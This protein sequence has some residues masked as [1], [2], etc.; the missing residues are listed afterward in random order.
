MSIIISRRRAQTTNAW[1][2]TTRV[3][4][5]TMAAAGTMAGETSTS[6]RA[7]IMICHQSPLTAINRSPTF[8][9]ISGG[10]S[11]RRT[12]GFDHCR[13]TLDNR[14]A[15]RPNNSYRNRVL[16]SCPDINMR[17]SVRRERTVYGGWE[18]RWLK[19]SRGWHVLGLLGD[20][21]SGRRVGYMCG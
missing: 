20:W 16:I 18:R 14:V 1:E 19:H 3:V 12:H 9:P 2:G 17:F 11:R 4:V 21:R 6:L 10:Q 7:L 5:A 15:G 8:G 13:R